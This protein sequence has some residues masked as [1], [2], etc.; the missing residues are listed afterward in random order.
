[1]AALSTTDKLAAAH[2]VG[3]AARGVIAASPTAV[4]LP[5]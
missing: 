1:M 2:P 3:V 4:L 5:G